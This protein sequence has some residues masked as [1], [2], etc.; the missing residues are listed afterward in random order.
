MTKDRKKC[1]LLNLLGGGGEEEE[2]EEEE[3]EEEEGSF[4]D[5]EVNR[6]LVVNIK[7]KINKL[8]E[9]VRLG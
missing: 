4:E 5:E 8:E 2:R 1:N 7:E 9:T 3:E 6:A